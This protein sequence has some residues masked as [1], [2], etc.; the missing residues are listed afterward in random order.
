MRCPHEG[1]SGERENQRKEMPFECIDGT[2]L[3]TITK[4]VMATSP[5]I[6]PLEYYA[7]EKC[8]EG[9]DDIK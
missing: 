9:N 6:P 3:D 2:L 7:P 1:L 8:D 4:A 5:I